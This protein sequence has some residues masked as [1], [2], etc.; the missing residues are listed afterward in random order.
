MNPKYGLD[1]LSGVMSFAQREWLAAGSTT[2]HLVEDVVRV[3]KRFHAKYRA[4]KEAKVM[5]P[6]GFEPPT[7]GL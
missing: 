2:F 5:G 6:E 4:G 7:E 3:T 1:S